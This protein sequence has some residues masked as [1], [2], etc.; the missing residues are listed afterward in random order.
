M[1]YTRLTVRGSRHKAEL[2]VPEDEPISELLPEIIE[3]LEEQSTGA[4]PLVLATLTGEALDHDLSLVD[5]DVQHGSWVQLIPIDEAPPP[6]IV[7]D[8][9][10]AMSEARDIHLDR[11]GPSASAWTASL[12][13]GGLGVGIALSGIAWSPI[14]ASLALMVFAVVAAVA[15]VWAGYS[16][17]STFSWAAAALAGGLLGPTLF[18]QMPLM[19]LRVDSDQ[20]I[21]P[22]IVALFVGLTAPTALAAFFGNGKRAV[23]TAMLIIVGWGLLVVGLIWGGVAVFDAAA[24]SGIAAAIAVGFIPSA[25][26]AI[27]GVTKFDDQVLQ[28]ERLARGELELTIA[29]SFQITAAATWVL[30]AI[31]AVSASVLAASGNVWAVGLALALALVFVT[32]TRMLPLASVRVAMIG[33]AAAPLLVWCLADTLVQPV[34]RMAILIALAAIGLVVSLATYTELSI[35]RLRRFASNVEMFAVIVLVP[36]ALGVM[37]VYGDLLASYK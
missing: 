17:K 16:N 6:P 14:G 2:V 25:S 26:L 20:V 13:L 21:V 9:T 4:H 32:R 35:A 37:G 11:W 15:S 5:Q 19:N 1:E 22:Q 12:A 8:V 10:Q 27:A 36:L 29:E 28:G 23:G 3:L 7:V 33:A 31:G 24:W 34:W 30:S 18:V